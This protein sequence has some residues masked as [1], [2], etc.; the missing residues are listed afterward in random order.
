MRPNWAEEQFLTEKSLLHINVL[1][2]KAVLFALKSLCSHLRQTHIKVLSD[3][4]TAVCAINNMGSCKLLLCDQE[5]RRI[6]SW[7]IE[8]WAIAA[9]IPGILNVE[10]DQESRKSEL[11][12]EWKLHESIFGYVQKYLNFYPSV[13]L[14][15]SRIN[16]QLPRLFAY[17]PDPKAEVIN[18][19]CVSWHNLSFYC[20]PPFSCIGKVLQKIISDNATGILIVPNWPSQFWFTVLQDLLLIEAFT[21]LLNA[22]NLPNQPDLKHPFFRNLELMACLVSG[23]A[24][25]SSSIYAVWF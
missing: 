13:D 22:D 17:R 16:A 24:L 9:H 23:K 11:R 4:T 8:S 10:A 3:N 19:F 20:F 21:I 5:V 7:A 15:A 12:T 14:F 6:W 25:G 1:E 2:L 18:A